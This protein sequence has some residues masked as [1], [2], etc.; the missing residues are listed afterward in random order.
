[1][2]LFK[3]CTQEI[4]VKLWKFHPTSK[5]TRIMAQPSAPDEVIHSSQQHRRFPNKRFAI[6][7]YPKF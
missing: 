4:Y 1:M 6:F 2:A 7:D 5:G 3:K